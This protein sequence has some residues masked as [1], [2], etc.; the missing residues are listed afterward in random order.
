M[1]NSS[2]RQSVK[3]K[4]HSVLSY[5]ESLHINHECPSSAFSLQSFHIFVYWWLP[6][7][8]AREVNPSRNTKRHDPVIPNRPFWTVLFLNVYWCSC[9][10]LYPKDSFFLDRGYAALSWD[11]GIAW[12]CQSQWDTPC[13]HSVCQVGQWG[14]C[15]VWCLGRSSGVHARILFL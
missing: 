10:L 6:S 4:M 5:L 9:T 2:R 12:P 11:L 13:W 1:L 3:R 15:L 14:N 8:P 7:D